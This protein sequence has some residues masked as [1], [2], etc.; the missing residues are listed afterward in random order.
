MKKAQ[1]GEK[2]VRKGNTGECVC[3]SWN[4]DPQLL[5]YCFVLLWGCHSC[6]FWTLSFLCNFRFIEKFQEWYRKCIYTSHPDPPNNFLPSNI[7]FPES[8]EWKLQKCGPFTGKF[9]N[10]PQQFGST[11]LA[12]WVSGRSEA[13]SLESYKASPYT[14]TSSVTSSFSSPGKQR[15]VSIV[16]PVWAF[17]VWCF[18][19]SKAAPVLKK[20]SSPPTLPAALI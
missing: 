3:S 18:L 17:A 11:L 2:E 7:F 19:T 20:Y 16:L 6:F 8:F 12:G 5:C 4:W 1:R 13:H 10:V 15:A 14:L 9:F